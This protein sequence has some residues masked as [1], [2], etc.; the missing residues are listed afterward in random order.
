MGRPRL[1]AVSLVLPGTLYH[2]L[3]FL[4]PS[5][6]SRQNAFGKGMDGKR[7]ECVLPSV[8]ISLMIRFSINVCKLSE[9]GFRKEWV[10]V[11]MGA[12]IAESD[13]ENGGP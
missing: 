1:E 6:T 5:H 12:T 8:Q 13:E 3:N 4:I 11:E 10:M 9:L 7:N 2:S